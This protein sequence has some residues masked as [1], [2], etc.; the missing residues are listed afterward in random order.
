MIENW[1][2]FYRMHSVQLA[3]IV[4]CVAGL[5][6]YLPALEGSIPPWA[7]AIASILVIVARVIRQPSLRTP[8]QL[9]K[10]AEKAKELAKKGGLISIV[11]LTVGCS[12]TQAQESCI[13]DAQNHWRAEV[14]ACKIEGKNAEQCELDRLT[15]ERADAERKCLK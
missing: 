4:A 11:L 12:T 1:K 2:Q 3:A 7:Y 5:E 14:A 6:A 13:L 9:W 15:E 10:E 8:E